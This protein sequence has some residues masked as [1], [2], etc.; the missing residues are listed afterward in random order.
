MLMCL[1]RLSSMLIHKYLDNK[2]TTDYR[3]QRL[4][5]KQGKMSFYIPGSQGIAEK[6]E[7]LPY[8]PFFK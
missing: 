8:D 5:F 2:K 6:E 3:T 1:L 4:S 7:R